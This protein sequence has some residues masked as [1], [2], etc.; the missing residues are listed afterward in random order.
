MVHQVAARGYPA[1]V[2]SESHELVFA[3]CHE[4]RNLLTS[5]QLQAD[6]LDVDAAGAELRVARERFRALAGRSGALLAQVRALLEGPEAD[7]AVE[8]ADAIEALRSGLPESLE[9]QVRLELKSA[10]QAPR[11]AIGSELL[12]QLLLTAV[13]GAV[14]AAPDGARLRVSAAREQAEVVFRV[15]GPAREGAAEGSAGGLLSGRALELACADAI[16]TRLG[17]GARVCFPE[18][19]RCALLRLP[20]P[21]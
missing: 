8:P 11:V 9:A 6:L 21:A 12:H 7:A 5:V 3:L 14:E 19:R 20:V 18:G 1:A 17:G 10:A 16:L 4:V 2:A 13:F 15:E